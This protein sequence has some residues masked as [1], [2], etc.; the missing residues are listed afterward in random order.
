MSKGNSHVAGSTF[1]DKA[2]DQ[3][4]FSL[5]EKKRKQILINSQILL[6]QSPQDWRFQFKLTVV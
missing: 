1:S 2:M 3:F 6:I 5:I 4:F